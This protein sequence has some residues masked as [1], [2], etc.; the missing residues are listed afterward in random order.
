[1][2]IAFLDLP[3]DRVD[4]ISRARYDPDVEIVLV[5][6]PDPDALALK[7]AEVL[8][9]PRS[10]EPLD[11]LQLKPDRVALPS[12]ASPSASAL[13]RAGISERIFVTLDELAE[14]WPAA[15]TPSTNNEP[16]PIEL[17]DTDLRPS[18]EEARL[19][20][21]RAALQLSEDRQLLFREV[22]ELAVE[23]TRAD[24]GS[25]MLV[26]EE[27]GE[28]R[29]A[30]ADG[31]PADVV[32][33]SR[34][35][36]GEGIAGRVALEGTPLIINEPASDR[37]KGAR[38][39]ARIA[40]ALSAPLRVG[41]RTIGV[42][43]VSRDRPGSP[44][45]E[46]DLDGLVAI[47]E[48]ISEILERAIRVARREQ[49]ALELR[50]RRE[51]EV[52]FGRKGLEE[53]ERFRLVAGRL[54]ELLGADA[55]QIH[56]AD[57]S[58][59]RFR[60]ISSAGRFGEEGELPLHHGLLA[61][62][63]VEQRPVHL[64]ARSTRP[65]D[66]PAEETPL[67]MIA[68]PLTGT[69]PLGVLVFECVGRSAAGVEELERWTARV[70]GFLARSIEE[71]EDQTELS[72]RSALLGSLADTAARIIVS[73][74]VE[75][76]LSEVLGAM[77]SLFPAALCTVRIR[78]EGG[79]FLFRSGFEGREQDRH[80]A[81]ELESTLARRTVESRRELTSTGIHPEE[82]RRA[83][84][85]HGVSGYAF[86][87]VRA[88]EEILG[89]LAAL[90]VGTKRGGDP[91]ASLSRLD[92]QTLRKLALYVSLALEQARRG[93]ARPERALE[94]PVTG[95]LASAG[96]ES[97]MQDEVKRAERYRERFVVTLC[98]IENFDTLH[99][100]LG[101]AWTEGFLKEF[102]QV[103]RR[104]VREVD[105]VA[106]IEDGRFAVL[107]PA[108]EKDHGALLRRVGGLVG[109]L[110]SVRSLPNA[111]D[112]RLDGRQYSFPDEI[113][114]GGELLTILRGT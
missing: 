80:R 96:F 86:I 51:I 14:G 114:T 38:V 82:L 73:R 103:L 92:I 72:R 32:R 78:G 111:G 33:T 85:E 4:L 18:A 19:G 58:L 79:G 30:F 68:A 41:G 97:R 62:V 70:A 99:E 29:I 49:D 15:S 107:S 48:Q 24:A 43:N 93:T 27:E 34:Q 21:L 5:A 45:G 101:P 109:Q 89:V 83:I 61:R 60:T 63:Y 25:I 113:A 3:D 7:I 88:D 104:N 9:I 37:G 22:L 1:M 59:D 40:A 95:L 12:L 67:N 87:P 31:L 81:L 35:K 75:T 54:A 39:R 13:A 16:N 36:L 106:R 110:A 102:A 66:G 10:T 53:T 11:L 52:A 64:T 76:L 94:D 90:T 57:D 6:H 56:L 44:F 100:R 20:R 2:K 98:A 46:E 55:A 26:D 112:V 91:A 28:L 74:D 23:R 71:Q 77:R 84:E 69:R 105:A 47:A 8:Q 50:M 42:L 108:S 17:W 65:A